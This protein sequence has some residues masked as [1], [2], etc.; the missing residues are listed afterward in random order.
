MTRPGMRL[1]ALGFVTLTSS[2]A[3]QGPNGGPTLRARTARATVASRLQDSVRA[4]MVRA[5]ADSAFPGG[6]AVVGNRGGVLTTYAIGRLDAA[7]STAPSLT[8]LYDLASLTKVIATTT[9]MLQLVD[10]G[11]VRLSA[12]VTTYL[13]EW[14]GAGATAVT[15]RHLLTHSS[16]LAAWRP[17]YKEAADRADA[18]A[19]LMT[20]S[21]DVAPDQRYLYSDM[22]FMLLGMVIERVTGLPLDQAFAQRV[23]APLRL[24]DTRFRPDSST[25]ARTAPTE[26]DPWRQRQPRG[27]VHDE[28]AARF[29]GVSGHAGLFATAEDLTRIARLWLNGGSLDGVR[30]A[31]AATVR[32]FTTVFNS[33]LSHRALGWETPNGTNSAGR[34]LSAKSF[35]HT[36][37]TGTSIWMDPERDLF[38]VLLTNRVNPT[39]RNTRIGG[40]R[41][42]LADAV[43]G[44]LTGQ[45]AGPP[46]QR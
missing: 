46:G 39:R 6:V 32:Q 34:R 30:F 5:L 25:L 7:D 42:G 29:D 38:V 16:G 10:A 41:T 37:F 15:I 3:A 40:V 44:A 4:V 43:V 19:Q 45:P 24:R 33:T 1:L 28:N 21:P 13:P 14:R 11:T 36:G 8:T 12:P 26:F 35:G 31:S 2:C 27:E 20:V 23:A 18:R 9:L 17:F 22:N